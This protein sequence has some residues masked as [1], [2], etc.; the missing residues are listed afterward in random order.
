MILHPA[1]GFVIVNQ[2]HRHAVVGV[3]RV[4]HIC[5]AVERERHA[6][7]HAVR[8]FIESC[9]QRECERAGQEQRRSDLE[10]VPPVR[11][12]LIKFLHDP[13]ERGSG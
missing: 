11:T 8:D 9:S 4:L 7:C 2:I 10:E 6:V 13:H 5:D 3:L 1:D 12:P